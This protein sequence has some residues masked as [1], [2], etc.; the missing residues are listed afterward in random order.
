MKHPYEVLRRLSKKNYSL[1][2]AYGGHAL[3]IP[4][5]FSRADLLRTCFSK[6]NFTS[7]D[8]SLV[9]FSNPTLVGM[10]PLRR[11]LPRWQGHGLCT[12]AP[13]LCYSW[14][15]MCRQRCTSPPPPP[16]LKASGEM[17]MDGAERVCMCLNV[18]VC[19]CECRCLCACMRLQMHTIKKREENANIWSIDSCFNLWASVPAA[20]EH[21]LCRMRFSF[22]LH[23]N[24][25]QLS[26]TYR[27]CF[28]ILQHILSV[29]LTKSEETQAFA[30]TQNMDIYSVLD[31][32]PFNIKRLNN[33]QTMQNVI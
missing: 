3:N 14:R 32:D 6:C 20:E 29:I 21:F 5:A 23:T 24:V 22:P 18:C 17:K 30:F 10:F 31:V 11:M 8:A 7:D 19:G 13:A 12:V 33:T 25:F 28:S 4:I 27:L 2:H 1:T 15:G 16:Q 26:V 9:G